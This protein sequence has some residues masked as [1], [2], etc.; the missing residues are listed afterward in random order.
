MGV[1]TTLQE[2]PYFKT[3]SWFNEGCE[4]RTVSVHLHTLTQS[5][6]NHAGTYRVLLATTTKTRSYKCEI[7]SML[8][9]DSSTHFDHSLLTDRQNALVH[10]VY[11]DRWIK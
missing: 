11:F 3:P 6:G 4:Y 8:Q 1:I 9:K 2:S 5:F 7:V 10:M